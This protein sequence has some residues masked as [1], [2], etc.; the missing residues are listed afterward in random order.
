MKCINY[1]LRFSLVTIV[2]LPVWLITCFTGYFGVLFI[3]IFANF[4]LIYER[5]YRNNINSIIKDFKEDISGVFI[6]Y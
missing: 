3:Y 4:G 6:F 1:I 2:V 5:K